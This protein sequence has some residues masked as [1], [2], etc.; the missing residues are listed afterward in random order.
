MT[1]STTVCWR[2][3]DCAPQVKMYCQHAVTDYDMCPSTCKFAVCN[4]PEHK[5]TWDPKYVFEPNIDRNEA[6]KHTCIHCEF[7]LHNGPK[8][9]PSAPYAHE[10]EDEV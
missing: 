7:F 6:L 2:T 9:D 8:K 3:R 1:S 10:L 4:R 5:P